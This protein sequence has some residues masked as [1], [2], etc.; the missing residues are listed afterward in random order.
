[1]T[2]GH[3]FG[4]GIA[5]LTGMA[6]LNLGYDAKTIYFAGSRMGDDKFARFSNEV[7]KDQYRVVNYSDIFV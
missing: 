1:M 2:T 4:G 3:S 5:Q 6:F 7:W